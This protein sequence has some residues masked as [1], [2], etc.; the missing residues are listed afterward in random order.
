MLTNI[1]VEL[2]PYYHSLT[3]RSSLP[4]SLSLNPSS[5]TFLLYY[6]LDIYVLVVVFVL[7]FAL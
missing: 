5:N 6:A 1:I 4:L 7:V 3:A 2:Y